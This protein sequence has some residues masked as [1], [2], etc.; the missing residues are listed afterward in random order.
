LPSTPC[1]DAAAETSSF[2]DDLEPLLWYGPPLGERPCE[3]RLRVGPVERA[4]YGPLPGTRR[5]FEGSNRRRAAIEEPKRTL[6][7]PV[8]PCMGPTKGVVSGPQRTVHIGLSRSRLGTFKGL[9]SKAP[10]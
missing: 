5:T 1:M 10:P 4:V 7:A 3:P 9:Q 2:R 8:G 6:E